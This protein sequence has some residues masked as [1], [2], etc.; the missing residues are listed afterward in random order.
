MANKHSQLEKTFNLP[1]M[2]ELDAEDI[3]E[4]ESNS[5]EIVFDEDEDGASYEELQQRV[6][7]L[8]KEIQQYD[9][10]SEISADTIKKY[11]EHVDELHLLA[12]NGYEEVFSA[13]LTLDPAQGS[14]F[15]AGAAKLLEIALRSKNSTMEK[16]IEM[17]KLQIQREKMLNETRGN[18]ISDIDPEDEEL[19]EGGRP[20]ENGGIVYNRNDLVKKRRDASNKDTDVKGDDVP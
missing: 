7:A 1:S 14:K 18:R 8:N 20:G 5:E 10:M 15:L 16:Q 19:P 13:A 9:S 12:K 3:E 2:D 11:N 4:I 17:A 6:Q